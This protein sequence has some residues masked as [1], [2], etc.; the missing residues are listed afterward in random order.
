MGAEIK[1]SFRAI[2]GVLTIKEELRTVGI[3]ELRDGMPAVLHQARPAAA[4]KE[5][6]MCTLHVS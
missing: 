4:Q 5:K 6:V 3:S 1:D 2:W